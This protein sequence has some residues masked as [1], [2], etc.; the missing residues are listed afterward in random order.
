MPLL[1]LSVGFFREIGDANT[2][3]L[4]TSVIE[5]LPTLR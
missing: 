4:L 5:L 2:A 1:L 3:C